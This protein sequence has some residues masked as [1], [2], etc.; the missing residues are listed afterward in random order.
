MQSTIDI[1]IPTAR[2]TSEAKSFTV[3]DISIRLPLRTVTVFKRYSE[4][5]ELNRLITAQAAT[6]PPLSLPPKHYFSS[7]TGNATLTESRR[8]GLEAYLQVIN[9]AVDPRWR[10]TPAWRSFLSLPSNVLPRTGTSAGTLSST[11]NVSSSSDPA[12]WLDGHR[13]LKATLR[14]ARSI[15]APKL[16]SENN[17]AS[18]ESSV[19]AKSALVRAGNMLSELN[20]GLVSRK[21]EWGKEKLGEGEFRRRRDLLAAGRQEI[22][23]LENLISAITKKKELDEVLER[24]QELRG[25]AT[26]PSAAK[27]SHS[28]ATKVGRGRV[29][30]RETS[31]TRELDN[32]GVLELQKQTMQEQDEDIDLIAAAVK[33]QKELA[34][35]INEELVVQNEML[36]ILDEDATRTDAKINIAKKRIAKIS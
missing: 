4:F 25:P 15:I 14:E 17:A 20:R 1:T 23:D 3:Y 29:L 27:G 35:Q 32:T 10:D 28:G 12:I 21:D 24:N 19:A 2:T 18:H 33:R 22:E 8:V 6:A 16:P 11:G 30:G 34:I 31:R 9:S 36:S 13:R 7:T 5:A 26:P